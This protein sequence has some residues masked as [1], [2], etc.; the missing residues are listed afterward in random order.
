MAEYLGL[1]DCSCYIHARR[2]TRATLDPTTCPYVTPTG[3]SP[4]APSRPRLLR[5]RYVGNCYGPYT[6]SPKTLRFGIQFGLFP[7]RSLLLG[8]SL[9]CFLF[10]FI[11]RCFNSERSQSSFD[12]GS[13]RGISP[14]EE[15]PLGNPRIISFM[16]LPAAYRCSSRPSSASQPS[17]PPVA[18]QH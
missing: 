17:H 14:H 8:E 1:A 5:L 7:F 13:M 10:L 15:V 18:V 9:T 6:T 12:T 3:V 2:P 4:S 16:R 11:L